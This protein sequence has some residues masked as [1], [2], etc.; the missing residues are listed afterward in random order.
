MPKSPRRGIPQNQGARKRRPEP[1]RRTAPLHSPAT[2]A[3]ADAPAPESSGAHAGPAPLS[4][5]S[6][7]LGTGNRGVTASRSAHDS[8]L[9]K[10]LVRIGIIA[11]VIAV[12]LAILTFL[13]R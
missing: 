5:A 9:N 6:A 2:F 12:G 8:L 10:E 11:G 13:F 7:R 4:E 3:G 1:Q